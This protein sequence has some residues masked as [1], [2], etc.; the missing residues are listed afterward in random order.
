MDEEA[1][2]QFNKERAD[3]LLDVMRELE[4]AVLESV[5]EG[6]FNEAVVLEIQALTLTLE[7]I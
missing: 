6:C 1:L 3:L 4:L 2:Q 7:I 5:L